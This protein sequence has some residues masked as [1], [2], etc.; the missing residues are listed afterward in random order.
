MKN[1]YDNFE[2]PYLTMDYECRLFKKK[3]VDLCGSEINL[4][5]QVNVYYD[6]P[7]F[8][9]DRTGM[10]CSLVVGSRWGIAFEVPEDVVDI[11]A[12]NNISYVRI[13][14][15]KCLSYIQIVST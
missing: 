6:D 1:R 12:L 8:S 14:S 5:K 10:V 2:A 11:L 15:G 4:S 9:S 3:L 7:R 13:P